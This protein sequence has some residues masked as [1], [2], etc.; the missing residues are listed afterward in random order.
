[1]PAIHE[2][3]PNADDLLALEPEELA[4]VFLQSIVSSGGGGTSQG[5]AIKRGN[6]FLPGN[7]P[8]NGYPAQYRD[9]V[10]ESLAAAWVWLEREGML[11]PVPGQQDPDW[12][13][14]SERGRA[15]TKKENFDAYR[16]SSIF[17][18]KALHP[19]IASSTFALFIRGHYDTVVFEAFRAVEV[20]VRQATGLTQELVGSPLM[21]KAFDVNNGA[22]TDTSLVQS[23]KQAMSDLFAG[24]MGLFKNP[25]SHR[26]EAISKPEDAVDLVMFANYLLRL[27]DQRA[28]AKLTSA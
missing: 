14:I 5:R 6:L 28:A 11:L 24:A 3:I 13:F 23:E 19:A 20:A 12:V 9:R 16:Y 27:V 22:L 17:P 25:T 2:L 15:L 8:V 10:Y 4:V 1:M 26:S 7:S 18:R 21:R